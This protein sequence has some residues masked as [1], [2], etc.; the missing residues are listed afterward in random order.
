MEQNLVRA[1]L[2]ECPEKLIRALLV[3]AIVI[4]VAAL[5]TGIGVSDPD[6]L[7]L[8]GI[9]CDAFHRG[10]HLQPS[11]HLAIGGGTKAP[12]ACIA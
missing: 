9:S 4:K 8:L 11:I 6:D 1:S 3:P 12:P 5:R 7:E 10:T 2:A